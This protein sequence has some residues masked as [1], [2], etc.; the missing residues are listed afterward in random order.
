MKSSLPDAYMA[1]LGP[2]AK[3]QVEMGVSKALEAR[4]PPSW[5]DLLRDPCADTIRALWAPAREQLPRF[6]DYL[7]HSVE[8]A[9]VIELGGLVYMGLALPDWV[10]EPM[11]RQPG[12]C[13]MGLPTDAALLKIFIDRV[14]PIPRSLESLWSVT[15]FI[16]TKHPSRICSLEPAARDVAEEPEIF[17]ASVQRSPE[18]PAL[19]CLKIAA[20]NGQMITCM[21]R[22]PGQAHWDDT[23]AERFRW[24]DDYFYVG[25]PTLDR[26]LSDDWEPPSTSDLG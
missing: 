7:A 6:I 15:S 23:L 1:L 16:D 9:A 5:R 21:T 8:G 2:A 3:R 4:L 17:P 13:W 25:K 12:F 22:P 24:A 18:Q 19:E 14:G 20:V 10:E 26:M 11:E